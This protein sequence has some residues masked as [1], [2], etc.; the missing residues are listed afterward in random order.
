MRHR[1]LEKK[2]R[3]GQMETMS[4]HPHEWVSPHW[5]YDSTNTPQRLEI[6]HLELWAKAPEPGRWHPSVPANIILCAVP[7]IR[8]LLVHNAYK[9]MLDGI[10]RLCC[11]A[12]GRITL[13]RSKP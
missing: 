7:I 3:H 8:H 11:L 1:W 2:L 9:A 12:L 5:G 10:S 6:S 13:S 4:G